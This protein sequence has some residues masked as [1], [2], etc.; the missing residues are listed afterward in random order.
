MR[1]GTVVQRER[2]RSALLNKMTKP[3]GAST[4]DLVG[5]RAHPVAYTRSRSI[6]GSAVW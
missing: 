6:G 1:R 4:L 2:H 3:A 5:V